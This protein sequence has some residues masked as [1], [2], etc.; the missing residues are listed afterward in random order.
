MHA[1]HSCLTSIYSV[2][3]A[4][5]HDACM[6]AYKNVLHAFVVRRHMYIANTFGTSQAA[7]GTSPRPRPRARHWQ[8]PPL[9]RSPAGPRA[10]RIPSHPMQRLRREL[11]SGVDGDGGLGDGRGRGRARG[12][13]LAPG[14]MERGP[15]A[16]SRPGALSKQARRA[17]P[18]LQQDHEV[19]RHC[20]NTHTETQTHT[21]TCTYAYA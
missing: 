8:Q 2:I 16:V 6:H 4:R 20:H 7:C 17:R 13:R 1:S 19:P 9:Q 3:Y 21:H 14:H 10:Q 5:T 12:L 18:A 15:D 11:I